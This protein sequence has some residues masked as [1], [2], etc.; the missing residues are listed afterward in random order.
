MILDKIDYLENLCSDFLSKNPSGGKI[1]IS[2]DLSDDIILAAAVNKFIDDYS[3]E[4]VKN[5]SGNKVL[6]F[7]SAIRKFSFLS[8]SV[9]DLD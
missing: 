7:K 5:W 4:L 3:I 1:N 2:A 8:R 9:V 6:I